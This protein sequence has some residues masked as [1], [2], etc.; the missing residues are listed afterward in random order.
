MQ[1]DSKKD[2]F[3]LELYKSVGA[4]Q[5]WYKN[6]KFLGKGG[7]GTAFLVQA[8]SGPLRGGLFALKVFHKM[9]SPVRQERFLKETLFLRDASHPNLMRL[10]DEGTY[11][12]RPFVVQDYMPKTLHQE[13][14]GKPLDFGKAIHFSCQLLSALQA[15]HKQN[16]IHRDIKPQN[17]F[18]DN[19]SVYLGDFGLIKKIEP[20]IDEDDAKDFQG[21][22]A[23]P[24]FYRTPE[25]IKYARKEGN[26]D[27]RSDIFQLGLVIAQMFSGISPL[28]ATDDLLSPV[29]LDKIH[30]IPGKHAG[31]VATTVYEMLTVDSDRRCTI[32]HALSRFTGLFA[33]YAQEYEDFHGRFF[34]A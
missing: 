5:G 27:L 19:L 22:F 15:L 8:T 6:F 29:Q 9:S 14:D 23:M 33:T 12:E 11:A 10:I 34:L 25:L 26:L 28:I 3:F 1:D 32:D 17:I 13:L 30:R 16:I 7:N 31:L 24:R 2:G 18:V 20:R 21:Y 4:S